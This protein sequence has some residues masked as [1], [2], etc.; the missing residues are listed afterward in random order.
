MLSDQP[1]DFAICT[2]TLPYKVGAGPQ[3]LFARSLAVSTL[4]RGFLQRGEHR[5][6][7][8]ATEQEEWWASADECGE[9]S[10]NTVRTAHDSWK[11]T[12][13]RSLYRLLNKLF[14]DRLPGCVQVIQASGRRVLVIEIG[15][16]YKRIRGNRQ[17]FVTGFKRIIFLRLIS[18]PFHSL[19]P[20]YLPS[21]YVKTILSLLGYRLP[22][23]CTLINIQCQP[24]FIHKIKVTRPCLK[25]PVTGG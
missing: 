7:K 21:C 23:L 24:L 15:P 1:S 4:L 8:L 19:Q 3:L 2:T 14:C 9:L 18:P 13:Y 6:L 10:H 11:F 17:H 5:L 16:F 20:H 22:A 12:G 25:K